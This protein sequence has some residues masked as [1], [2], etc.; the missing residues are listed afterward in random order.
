[1]KWAELAQNSGIFESF[2]K[3]SICI[4]TVNAITSRITVSSSGMILHIHKTKH[5]LSKNVK[6]L[7]REG[8]YF[9][10]TKTKSTNSRGSYCIIHSFN[11]PKCARFEIGTSWSSSSKTMAVRQLRHKPQQAGD[12]FSKWSNE[13]I[14]KNIWSVLHYLHTSLL[15][16]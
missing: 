2:N 14:P 9:W 10:G 6:I 4:K 1:M 13:S 3:M 11:Y 7:I 5:F 12:L 8:V 16:V 15:P